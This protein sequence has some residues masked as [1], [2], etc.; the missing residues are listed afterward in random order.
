M[1]AKCQYERCTCDDSSVMAGVIY[2]CVECADTALME[3]S[4]P[5]C[6]CGHMTCDAPR[7]PEDATTTR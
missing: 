6:P 2:C 3:E 1:S 5:W 4:T 7:K